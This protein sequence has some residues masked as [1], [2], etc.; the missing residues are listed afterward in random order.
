MTWNATGRKN[1]SQAQDEA[2][3]TETREHQT[4]HAQYPFLIK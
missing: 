4:L 2:G 3:A 1:H